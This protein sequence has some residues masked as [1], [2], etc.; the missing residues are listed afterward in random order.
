MVTMP[1][2]PPGTGSAAHAYRMVHV[3]RMALKKDQRLF[4][5]QVSTFNKHKPVRP[6]RTWH[7][8]QQAD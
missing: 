4:Y 1:G 7:I 8:N 5:R 2:D 3:S 6:N